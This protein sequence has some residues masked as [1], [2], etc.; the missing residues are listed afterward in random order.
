MHWNIVLLEQGTHVL[1]KVTGMRKIE[2]V[3]RITGDSGA[4]MEKSWMFWS[5][6]GY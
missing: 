5:D 1:E 6:T 2:I 4:I 3:A